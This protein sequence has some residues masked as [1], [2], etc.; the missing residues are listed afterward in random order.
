MLTFARGLALLVATLVFVAPAS[1]QYLRIYYPDIEQGSSTVLVAPT[2]EAMIIDA[3]SALEPSDDDVVAFVLD[4]KDA[5][6]ITSL[7]YVVATHYD[8]DHIGRLEEILFL[9]GVSPSVV[10]YDRGAFFQTPGSFAY[11]DY[12]FA[13]GLNNRTTITP[14]TNISLG[15]GVTVE[16]YVVNGDLR[17]GS[18]VTITSSSQFENSASVGLVIRFGNFDVWIGGDLT[19]EPSTGVV[20]VETPVGP[21]A[22]DVDIYTL[23]HHGS[24][25]SSNSSFLAQLK[26][27][28][29]INQNSAGNNFGHPNLDVVNRFKGTNDTFGNAPRFY[30]QNPGNPTDTRSD[31]TLATAIADP[32]DVD[33]AVGLPGTITVITD[34][35]SYQIFAPEIAPVKLPA[36]SGP[37][38]LADFPPTIQDITRSPWVPLATESVTVTAEI[39]DETTFTA[40]IQWDLDGVAQ[41]PVAMTSIGSNLYEGTIPAL[42]DGSRVDYRVVATDSGTQVG[43]SFTQGYFSGITPVSTLQVVD[44]DGVLTTKGYAARVE[45]DITA[46]P[47]VYSG[48]VSQIWGEDSTGGLQI[49]DRVL[50]PINR[51][52]VVQF[53][54]E[55]EQFSGITELNISQAFGNYGYTFQSAGSGVTPQVITASQVGESLEGQL[56]RVNGVE[57]TSGTIAES[58]SSNLTVSPD[59][60]TTT[61][62]V[63]V[64]SDTDIP[65][66]ATPT[67]AF[68]VIGIVSQFDSTFPYTFGYQI[69]PR[70]RA[71][72][73]SDEINLPALLIHEIHADPD[74]SGGDANGDGSVSSTQDEFIEFVNPNYD[75]LDISGWTVADAI[76]V[77]HTFAN[78]TVVPARDAV[79]LF[80]GGTPTGDFGTAGANGLVFTAST[81]RLALNNSG[82]TVTLRDDLGAL[83]QEVT[84]GSE[85]GDNQSLTRNPD[86]ANGLLEKHLTVASG[87]RYSPGTGS[88]GSY[89][90]VPAG[91]VLLTEVLY[92][93]DGSDNGFE[94]VELHNA[95]T[96]PVDLSTMSLG[97]GGSN[98]TTSQW[99]LEGSLAAGA[100]VVVGGPNSDATN[101]NPV[102]DYEANFSPDLQNSGSTA[103]G[104]ALFNLR[105]SRVDATTVPVD[106]VIYGTNNSN[107]L[108][109]ET[110][111]AN[112]PE[113]GDA[114][115][116]ESIERTDVAGNWQ[117]QATPSPGSFAGS[118]GPGPGPGTPNLVL[119]E[120][121]YDASG[122]DNGLEWIEIHNAGT[123]SVDLSGWSLGAGGSDYTYS[124]TQLSGTIA[125]GAVFVVGGPTSH[126]SNGSPSFD[127]TLNFSP[128]LQNSG[129]TA[130]GVALFDVP[131]VSIT[132]STVP[133]DAV[134]Y[135]SNNNSNLIDETGSANAPEVGDA[136]AGSSIERTT[137][138]GAWQIQSSPTPGTSPL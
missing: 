106:A 2:G 129:S 88:D 31:D 60:G 26:A 97:A 50:L 45:I 128:D 59:G 12:S 25:T 61:F 91:V 27:E 44:V 86:F 4:L 119:S 47:G 116:G 56:V 42:T 79:V 83:V 108:I 70:G 111:S 138:A 96:V 21:L 16:A 22:W 48:F 135:G 80:S 14:G 136:S 115:G 29:G 43:K 11:S 85:G 69:L 68:D 40:E 126:S 1:A 121:F 76:Q 131:A 72:L 114:S 112:A 82:D 134:V 100:V 51:D 71:D 67:Q 103:D 3:G 92:D 64:D 104:V 74:S 24:R 35:D 90:R 77:R 5:G 94:W 124:T 130:D 49:F 57:V 84:Y 8:E 133:V 41:T 58:G 17:G 120:V 7:D 109:D 55:V 118:S 33:E 66:S 123:S 13:A 32:D 9:A 52:D 110:G 98:Y 99:Q 28:V 117:I 54:G 18:S 23:N 125:A 102:I 10:T 127:L 105:V 53:V 81:G 132:S 87:V 137:V 46:E 75:D 65:G 107:N 73:L 36:D 62:T 93:A 78:G 122:G 34:G 63:R 39:R 95:G 19:G 6:I 20:D 37:G 89:F 15:G 30:Q 101:G 113:V 38:T